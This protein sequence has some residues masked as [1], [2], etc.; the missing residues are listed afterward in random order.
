MRQFHDFP[1]TWGRVARVLREQARRGITRLHLTGGEP[2][3]HPRFVDTLALARRLGLRTSVGTNGAMLARP[4]FARR[5]LPLLDEVMLSLHGPGSEIHDA[6]T[7]RPGSYAA[8]LGA[9]AAV[10]DAGGALF[11]N[12][13]LTRQTL[14]HVADTVALAG[15]LGAR[16]AV[17][18]YPTPEGDALHAWADLAPPLHELPPC[19]REVPKAAGHVVVRFFGVPMCLLG[20]HAALSNDLHWDPRVTVEWQA[21]PGRVV[22]GEQVTLTPGRKRVHVPACVLCTRSE[23][24]PG[25]FDETARQGDVD[26]LRP[27]PGCDPSAGIGFAPTG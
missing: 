4:G 27:F 17:V 26:A 19:L 24:C 5:A 15:R 8:A 16:M 12:T 21:H 22:Y 11:T 14:P 23:V 13:V 6:A 7:E 3:L 2:T 20:E 25:V 18:S 9:A 1:V 10:A